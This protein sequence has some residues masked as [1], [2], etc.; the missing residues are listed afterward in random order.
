MREALAGVLALALIGLAPTPAKANWQY[1]T[2]GMTP[3]QVVAASNGAARLAPEP[4][5]LD[6]W[7]LTLATADYS[8]DGFAFNVRFLFGREDRR[9][10]CVVLE[11]RDYGQRFRL[12]S[13][14]TEIYGRPA[15]RIE[16]GVDVRG[17]A[18]LS[19]TVWNSENNIRLV[20]LPTID[21][22]NVIYCDRRSRGL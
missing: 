2:W 18:T 8:A 17:R 3:D 20:D 6:Q 22:A 12:E 14:L 19:T 16:E 5:R 10:Q 13:R 7:R 1:T 11:L 4:R 21:R 15:D 9:L